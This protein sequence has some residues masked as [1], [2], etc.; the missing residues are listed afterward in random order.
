MGMRYTA[1]DLIQDYIEC[2]QRGAG[3]HMHV[4]GLCMGID[5]PDAIMVGKHLTHDYRNSITHSLQYTDNCTVHDLCQRNISMPSLTGCG[6]GWVNLNN[7]D[8]GGSDDE[9]CGYTSN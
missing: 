4:H 5:D 1:R 3:E 9:D 8:E 6:Q 2:M 7:V